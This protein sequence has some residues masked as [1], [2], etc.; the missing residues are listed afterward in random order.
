M[1]TA[2]TVWLRGEE[3]VRR[4]YPANAALTPGHLVEVLSTGKVRKHALAVGGKAVPMFAVENYLVGRDLNTAYAQD[5]TVQCEVYSPGTEINALLAPSC[6]A[7]VVGDFL[8]SA[9][10]GT[11]RK[12]LSLTVTNSSGG[13]GETGPIIIETV[14]ATNGSD[15]STAIKDNFADV[16]AGLAL[17]AYANA[18][19]IATEAVD[20]SANASTSVRCSVMII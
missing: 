19:A 12:C 16:A 4:E 11:L 1:S 13:T 20:N 14:G 10:D 15:V 3:G 2:H 7:I 9:G 8:E 18:I 5:D 6:P 17:L